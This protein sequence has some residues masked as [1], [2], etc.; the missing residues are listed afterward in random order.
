MRCSVPSA[1]RNLSLENGTRPK[2]SL[3]SVE[4][5]PLE[6][7]MAPDEDAMC[8]VCWGDHAQGTLDAVVGFTFRCEFDPRRGSSRNSTTVPLNDSPTC[9]HSISRPFRRPA[10]VP[11]PLCGYAEVHPYEVLGQLDE[12]QGGA[13]RRRR[14][15]APDLRALRRGTRVPTM[16][17]RTNSSTHTARRLFPLLSSTSRS[18]RWAH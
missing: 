8:R 7:L 11:L 13:G 14:G 3:A 5:H 1:G 12:G 18:S 2:K 9:A 16:H 10:G 17:R 15:H 6:D 4:S